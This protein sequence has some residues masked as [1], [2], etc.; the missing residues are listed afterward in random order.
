MKTLAYDSDLCVGCGVCEEVCSELWFK[1]TDA[2]RSSIR[3]QDGGPAG[4]SAVFCDQCGDCIEVCP[5]EA[6]SRDKR[7]IVRLRKALCV[8]CLS[9]VGFCPRGAMFYHADQPEPFKCVAC[10]QC[11]TECPAEALAIVD[12]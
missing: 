6:L 3:I 1:A 4:L 12:R 11:V 9:C 10:G 2:D 5:T 8:G 7:G